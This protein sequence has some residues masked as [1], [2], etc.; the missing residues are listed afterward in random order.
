MTKKVLMALVAVAGLLICGPA[1]AQWWPQWGRD[2]QHSS[3]VPVTGQSADR[4]LADIIYDP[5]VEAERTDPL[6]APGLSV[7]YQV[8]LIDGNDIY[9]EFKGGTYTDLAHWETQSWSERRLSWQGNHLVQKWSFDSDWKPVPYSRSATGPAWEPVFHAVLANG[10]IYIPGAGGSL[11]RVNKTNGS[12]VTRIQPFGPDID[13]DTFVAGVPSV[14]SAGNVYYTAIKLSHGYPWNSDVVNAWLVRVSPGNA[15]QTATWASLTPGAP[16]GNDKCVIAFNV[17][18]LP[19]PPAPDA[20]APVSNCG[21]QRP[22]INAAPAIAPDGTIY[23]ISTAQLN[24]RAGYLVAVNPNLTPKWKASLADRFNDGCNVLLP[25]NGTPG[26]C[27]T[28][29]ATGVDPGINRAGGGRVLDEGTSSPTVAPDGSIWYGAY[30]RY[31]WAQGHLMKFSSSGQYLG[32]YNFGWDITPGIYQHGGTYSVVIKDNHYGEA[33]SYCNDEAYC[34]EDR[35]ETYPDNPE[36]YFITQLNPN[37][38]VEWRWQ[39]TNPLSCSRDANGQVTCVSD[40]PNGFE[41][42]I[43]NV[44]IDANGRVFG[45]SEDGNLYVVGQGGVLQDSFFL[46]LAIEAAYTPL[47]MDAQGRSY[48]QNFGH[49]YVIGH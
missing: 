43:N 40:H 2:A 16:A 33:G 18:Q 7:H 39:N 28:G 26:G 34:P 30:S 24:N 38:G 29:A 6:S 36:A 27:R 45:N 31:N 41:W 23:V 1:M 22:G 10:S 25:P 9:M 12:V 3:A 48:T 4:I 35:T 44:V 20:V 32:A 37:L 47:S 21:S 46:N 17:N 11:F 5:H 14:D 19:W 13:P 49:F 15:V 8:P 42:C